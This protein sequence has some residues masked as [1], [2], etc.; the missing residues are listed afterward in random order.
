[1]ICISMDRQGE[2]GVVIRQRIAGA[3]TRVQY[4]AVHAG[5]VQIIGKSAEGFEG[6]V[7]PSEPLEN[8]AKPWRYRGSDAWNT[9]GTLASR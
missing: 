6:A 1:M 4:C 7:K 9:K 3:N 2:G 5:A 8:R